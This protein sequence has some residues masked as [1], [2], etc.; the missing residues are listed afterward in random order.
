MTR[1]LNVGQERW[2]APPALLVQLWLRNRVQVST[3]RENL[4]F[5]PR[6]SLRYRKLNQR[7][8][9]AHIETEGLG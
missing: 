9:V 3:F 8:H 6:L 4:N 5:L 2:P 1:S 7:V